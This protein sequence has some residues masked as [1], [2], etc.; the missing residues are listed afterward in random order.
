[1]LTEQQINVIKSTIPLLESAGTALT[2][3]FYQR[4]FTH[5]PELKDVFN[6]ANQK[7]GRQSIALFQ[8]VAAYAKNIDN[9]SVLTGAVERIAHKHTSFNIQAEHYPVVGHHLIE[10]LRELAPEA[11]TPEVE[12]AWVA[13]Y[14]L[15]ASI[16]IGREGQLYSE[17]EQSRGGWKNARPF[18]VADKKKES[19]LV[20]SFTFEAEDGDAVLDY[21]P[22]QYIGIELQPSASEYKEIRQ[23]SLSQKPN[24]QNYRISVKREAGA[25]SYQN[26]M[27]SNYLHDEVNVGDRVSLYAPAGDFYY[28]EKGTPT[29]LISAGVGLTPMQAMLQLLAAQGKKEVFYLHACADRAQHSFADEVASIV[30]AHDWQQWLWYGKQEA[31]ADSFTGQMELSRVQ[32]QLP[33]QSADFY[34]CGPIG[35]MQFIVAQLELM[36][37]TRDRIHYEAFGPH[38]DL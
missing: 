25:E 34:L 22:G 21:I 3:H 12:E 28:Q 2:D 30:S 24:G 11:L 15:L 36:G 9:L 37:V 4:V 18:V 10:T 26:G 5:N 27:V 38:A 33:V 1:M 16:F 13:A 17:R 6:M 32:D 29:V 19:E 7:T 14:Q 31:G 8:A 23:Y 35:F 20:T